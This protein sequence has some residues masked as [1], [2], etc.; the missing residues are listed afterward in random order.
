MAASSSSASTSDSNNIYY[1]DVFLNHRGPD[2]KKTLASHLY[3]RLLSHGFRP[4]LDRPELQEG[5]SFIRQI[6][7][8]IRTSFVHVAIFSPRYVESKWC[9][10]ELLLMLESGAPIIPVF[11]QVEPAELRW[12]K[13]FYAEALQNLE[14]KKSYDAETKTEKPRYTSTTIENWRKALSRVAD[15][16]GFD[17]EAFNGDEG[18]MVDKI[19]ERVLKIF[20]TKKKM[21]VA[22]YPT[23]LDEKVKDIE[24]T[25][26][27][28]QH[29]GQ[30]QV[31]GIT[32]LGGVGKTTLAIEL[33]NR[34][35]PN[36]NKSYFLSDVRDT[37]AKSSL[38]AVQSKLLKG[39]TQS[40]L[41]VDNIYEGIEMLRRHLASS[42]ALLI[43][44]D[45]DHV[46][47]LDALLP[48]QV[49]QVLRSDSLILITS[50][51]KDVL[52]RS[53][54]LEESIY[55]LTGL[56]S[57]H[58]KELFCSYA[59]CQPYPLQGFEDLVDEFLEACN[60]LPLSLKVF[61]ALFCGKR[62]RSYWEDRLHQVQVPSDI[63][64]SLEIS[65]GSLSEEEKQMFLDI[66]CFF[67][68]KNKDMAI[69][70]WDGS[71]WQGRIGFQNLQ[72]KC[73]VDV[74]NEN[75]LKIDYFVEADRKNEI[76]MHDHLRDMGRQIASQSGLPHR[77]WRGTENIDDSLQQSPGIAEVRGIRIV[78]SEDNDNV[79]ND[80]QHGCFPWSR[81]LLEKFLMNFCSRQSNPQHSFHGIGMMKLQFL[82]IEDGFLEHIFRRV[83]SP[84]LIWLHW[85]KC[86]S[87]SLPSCIPMKNL[88][89]LEVEGDELKTLW[90]N[91]SQAPV[92]LRELKILGPLSMFPK[93]IGKLKH[94]QR[95]YLNLR[96]END[97]KTLPE[98]FCNL[99][100]LMVLELK[101]CSKLG[102]L[103][104]SFGNLT[105]LE[106]I[107]LS[108]CSKLERLPNSF[109]HLVRLKFLNLYACSNLTMSSETL[110]NIS[111]LEYINL[112]FCEKILV[113]PLQIARQRFLE[114]LLLVETDLK[115]LPSAIGDLI[116]LEVLELGSPML[117][118]LPPSLGELKNL[119]KFTLS[120]CT[121]LKCLPKSVGLL[122]QLTELAF[123]CPICELP[124]NKVQGEIETVPESRG[125]RTLSNLDKCCMLQLHSLE[126]YGTEIPKVSFNE[127]VCPNLRHLLVS[128]C[129]VLVE[130]GT[131]PN[132]LIKLELYY[133]D[134]LRN[135]KA[136]SHLGKLQSLYIR[137]CKELEDLPRIEALV[138]LEELQASG[139][140]Q[141]KS[142]QGLANLTKLRILSVYDCSELE[143]LPDVEHLRSLEKLW[144]F[145]CPKL[146]WGEG[147]VELLRQRVKELSL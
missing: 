86:P 39:L 98:E 28:Q 53:G 106:H 116:D 54:V 97:V 52:T 123:D 132:T 128:R 131:L 74:D 2:V 7:G 85:D 136:L 76:R 75:E 48:L 119:K 147:V 46:D 120:N 140:V 62:D 146:Q 15:I 109:G 79:V 138:S 141:L 121:E 70:I 118:T 117:E 77:F 67:I 22:K 3:Y 122:T 129:N 91:E 80:N 12:G 137:D 18:K 1:Y 8:A 26:L 19:V 133:C 82:D 25:V 101:S 17:L 111:T 83:Q 99:R 108:F 51:D 6:E 4:F 56:N 20:K 89:V 9:L 55:R 73:L 115:E 40:D 88:R 105:N 32:G 84:N 13:K 14:K 87:S 31:I 66:A 96:G 95:I 143:E 50:R 23:G 135:I 130:V 30:V 103:P 127:T 125:R 45:I 100:S 49:K 94:L 35:S 60:G 36:Y 44:D 92:Q 112:S 57:K 29:S 37:V 144:A 90:Q 16:S 113:L 65:Y 124:F 114:T 81:N 24:T 139:C 145:R 47:Q 5:D 68:G 61:G 34:K 142:I 42:Q 64:K 63:Q 93:F 72:N 21:N 58:S 69:R 27:L 107:D 38:H 11:Y 10:D 71:G 78:H 126:L 59:F 33:F 41:P 102:L 110:G 134:K 104:E 43:L